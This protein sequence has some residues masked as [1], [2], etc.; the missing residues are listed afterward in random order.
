[1]KVIVNEKKF[2]KSLLDGEVFKAATQ[3]INITSDGV[4]IENKN[5]NIK[6]TQFIKN[7]LEKLKHLNLLE[8]I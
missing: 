8:K 6:N 5:Y 1:M 2:I 3:S 7:N 4:I